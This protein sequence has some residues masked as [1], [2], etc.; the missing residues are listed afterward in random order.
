MADLARVKADKQ[1]IE[2]RLRD[3]IDYCRES[4]REESDPLDLWTSRMPESFKKLLHDDGRLNMDAI[5]AFRGQK[6]FVSEL[7]NSPSLW[8]LNWLKGRLRG[9]RRY[10]RERLEMMRQTGDIN[11]LSKYPL[12]RAGQPNFVTMG[13]HRFNE[14]WTRH[15]RYVRLCRE[16]LDDYLGRAQP[17]V[18]DIGGSYC[19]FGGLLK[20]EYPAVRVGVVEFP[21][22][23]ILSY[24]YL[25][26]I[27]PEARINTLKEANQAKVIDQAFV[28]RYDFLLIPAHCYAKIA[29]GVFGLITNFN[30]LGEMSEKWFRFY[31]DSP[32]FRGAP[33]LFTL[34][35]F[36]ARPTYPTDINILDY[37]LHEFNRRHFVISPLFLAYYEPWAKFFYKQ[38]YFSSQFFEF[39]GRRKS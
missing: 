20:R 18:L 26:T 38:V 8:P 25:A 1:A 27:F 34:N 28:S 16:H 19:L 9:E 6:M 37:P 21:E 14:R 31:V 13:G 11:Y 35:R 30:S 3:E 12:E 17:A 33:Y 39:I 36:H 5:E 15:V 23:L 32:V 10:C 7:P 22:Q 2:K 29:P 24:Y 4:C